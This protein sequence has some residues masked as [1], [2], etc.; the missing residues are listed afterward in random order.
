M[1]SRRCW[2]WAPRTPRPDRATTSAAAPARRSRRWPVRA[3]SLALPRRARRD[4]RLR[5]GR[6]EDRAPRRLAAADLAAR[7]PAADGRVLPGA[8]DVTAGRTRV[9]Y[10]AHAFMVGGAEEMVLNL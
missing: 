7:W 6:L 1:R 8:R 9:V 5:G 10:L 4:R 2:R 3:G